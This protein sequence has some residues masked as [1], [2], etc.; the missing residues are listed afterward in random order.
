MIDNDVHVFGRKCP[1]NYHE[2]KNNWTEG[3]NFAYASVGGWR[4]FKI[5]IFASEFALQVFTHT[6]AN[7]LSG[8]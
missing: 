5:N 8:S 1:L 6:R 2:Y 4:Y 7:F 3:S